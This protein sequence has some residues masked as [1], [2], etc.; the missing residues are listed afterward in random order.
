MNN[1]AT[2]LL[3]N[4]LKNKFTET[5]KSRTSHGKWGQTP[6]Y[7]ETSLVLHSIAICS[8]WYKY[9]LLV[10]YHI[11][12]SANF[13]IFSHKK[14][15]INEKYL[16]ITKIKGINIIVKKYIVEEIPI[17]ILEPVFFSRLNKQKRGISHPPLYFFMF[18]RN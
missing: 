14:S 18:T 10:N 13:T 4:R 8:C 1:N 5:L 16:K 3:Q 15:A 2:G 11:W 12:A 7:L 6:T 17:L 9:I